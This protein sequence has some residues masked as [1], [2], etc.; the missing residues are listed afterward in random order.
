MPLMDADALRAEVNAVTWWHTI[1]LGNGVVTPGRDETPARLPLLHLPPL[2]GKTVLDIGAWDGFYSFAAERLGAARV[3]ATDEYAWQRLGTGR[4]GFDLAHRA[5]DSKVEPV[6]IDV[7]DLAPEKLGGT[8]NV[9]L[10]LGVLYHLRDPLAA[11]DR[12]ANVT[13][14]LLVMETHVDMLGTRKPAAAFY[15][16]QEL[17]GDDTNWWGPNLPAVLGMLRA[18]GFRDPKVVHLTP[19][20]QR[21]SNALGSRLFKGRP[22]HRYS[23]GRVVV[24]ARRA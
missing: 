24:H 7:M 10:F 20:R 3:V 12:V 2:A 19:R 16:K 18:T 14:D 11:L 5:L 1:D 17:Y 22:R 13:G 9:V 6:E 8:F 21:I 15:P 23:H 4:Q